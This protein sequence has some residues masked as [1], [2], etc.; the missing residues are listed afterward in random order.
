MGQIDLKEIKLDDVLQSYEE[1]RIKETIKS[2]LIRLIG[3]SN[4]KKGCLTLYNI[5]WHLFFIELCIDHEGKVFSFDDSGQQI[6]FFDFDSYR[7]IEDLAG[8]DIVSLNFKKIIDKNRIKN[9]FYIPIFIKQIKS[10]VKIGEIILLY[11]EGYILEEKEGQFKLYLDILISHITNSYLRLRMNRKSLQLKNVIKYAKDIE[12]INS[13]DNILKIIED[14]CSYGYKEI[15]GHSPGFVIRLIEG[16]RLVAKNLKPELPFLLESFPIDEP[17]FKKVL[18]QN[19]SIIINTATDNDL[20]KIIKENKSKRP[21]LS[22]FLESLRSML[23]TPFVLD[24]KPKGV[25]IVYEDQKVFGESEKRFFNNLS[26]IT[27]L[28]YKHLDAYEKAE[29]RVKEKIDRL[30]LL[31]Q[32]TKDIVAESNMQILLDK[33]LFSGLKLVGASSGNIRFLKIEEGVLIRVSSSKKSPH[34]GNVLDGDIEKIPVGMGICGQVVKSGIAKKVDDAYTDIVWC[35]LLIKKMGQ[36]EF[37]RL[38]K[39]KQLMRSE[40]SAPLKVG[41]EKIGTIDAHKIEPYGFTDEDL[42]IFKDLALLAA[43]ALKRQELQ[44]RLDTVREIADSFSVITKDINI[45]HILRGFL[46]KCLVL[47]GISKG[48]IALEELVECKSKLKYIVVENIPGLIEGSFREIG[49]GIM[50]AAAKEQK[51]LSIDDVSNYSGHKDID[52]TIKSEIAAPMIFRDRLKGIFMIA[53]AIKNRFTKDD[54]ILLK[55]ITNQ[56]ALLIYNVQLLMEKEDNFKKMHQETIQ[57]M[58][59]MSGIMAHQIKNPLNTILVQTDI[60][61][62]KISLQRQDFDDNLKWILKG[63]KSA[64]EIIDKI[65]VFSKRAGTKLI[66]ANIHEVI[67]EAVEFIKG[68]RILLIGRIKV[69]LEFGENVKE[70]NFDRFQMLQVFLNLINNAYDSMRDKGDKLIITTKKLEDKI[71]IRFKDNGMGIS[72]SNQKKVFTSFFTTKKEIGTGLG[73]AVSKR[74]IEENHNGKIFFESEEGS[75]TTFIIELPYKEN[76]KGE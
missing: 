70:F 42:D 45:A 76:K 58:M 3:I 32:L 18:D 73:L 24:D 40:I 49:E 50:G 59:N 39:E 17:L 64:T 23:I 67:E 10:N 34:N 9:L 62:D 43:I 60:L 20:W 75:G 46:K 57:N 56:I 74:F 25:F 72:E 55:T 68:I 6:P 54:E 47:V 5:N 37:E 38:I 8:L 29:K 4:A 48:A 28:A 41:D 65:E 21:K 36:E 16:D 27:T 61:K 51:I 26:A 30:E 69:I 52:S 31:H 1:E 2:D 7:V 14:A 53:S 33:I 15:Y 19:E 63:I 71:E 35:N 66:S 22:K 11:D 44:E 12:K 13:K